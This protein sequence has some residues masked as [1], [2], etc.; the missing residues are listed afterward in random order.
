MDLLAGGKRSLAFGDKFDSP[1]QTTAADVA[2]MRMVTQTIPQAVPQLLSAFVDRRHQSLPLNFGKDGDAGRAG[3]GVSE[4]GVAVLEAGAVVRYGRVNFFIA[5][6]SA[7][8]LIAGAQAF[9][10]ADDVRHD[11]F[12][13]AREEGAGPP[14]CRT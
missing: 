6:Q 1:K 14:P 5:Q 8:R 11:T 12:L 10:D 7:Q 9:G 13:F 4:V 3:G 2:D